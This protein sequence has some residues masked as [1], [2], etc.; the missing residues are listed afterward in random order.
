VE[1]RGV[2]RCLVAAALFGAAAP[3]ASV[4]VADT[5]ALA[6]AG[7]LYLGAALA[8][9]PVVARRPWP[10][11]ALRQGWRPVAAAVVAGGAVGP[12]LLMSGI[13]RTDPASASILL[14]L[15]LVAT[16]ALAATVFREHLGP[17]VVAGAALVAVGGAVLVWQPGAELSAG[18]LLIAAACVCWGVDNCVTAGIDQ[19]SPEHVVLVKG[20]VA[21]T[22]N[23]GLGVVVAGGPGPAGISVLPVAAALAVGALGYGVSITQWVKGARDL[24]AARGQIIF[25]SAPFLGAAVAWL[26]LAEP[27]TGRQLVAVVLALAGVALSLETAHGHEHRHQRVAH[28][29]E[30]VHDDDHHDHAHDDGFEGRHVHAHDHRELVHAHPHV[31]DLHHRHG[32]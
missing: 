24:G 16:V 25:A 12:A 15:E 27:V 5:G 17:R 11:A 29:H 1:R 31:P 3:A 19:V 32:H 8:V 9:V 30:H 22:V 2:V 26:A 28:D 10:A 13:A 23:L 4:L 21:G 6:V 20:I 14:N 18:A 7:L